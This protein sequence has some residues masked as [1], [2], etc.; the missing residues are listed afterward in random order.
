MN[1]KKA[2]QI[3]EDGKSIRTGMYHTEQTFQQFLTAPFLIHTKRGVVKKMIVSQNEP[4]EVTSIKKLI[5]SD[6]ENADHHPQFQLV[7]KKAIIIPLD[8]PRYPMKVDL[9]N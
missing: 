8:T 9:G 7:T 2:H 6:L 5:A 3:L 4:T 1:L